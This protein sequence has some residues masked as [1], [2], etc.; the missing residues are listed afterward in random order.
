MRF[1]AHLGIAALAVVAASVATADTRSFSSAIAQEV[2]TT[3]ASTSGNDQELT[4][5]LGRDVQTR[6]EKDLGRIVD[7]LADSSGKVQAAVVELG[8]FLGIGTR[9]IVVEWS[10][11]TFESKD[12][13]AK[14]VLE[15]DRAQLRA[16]PEY[17][18]TQ[19]VVGRKA[20]D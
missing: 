2:G 1:P 6:A 15:M 17:K 13:S 9:K 5:V 19:P 18:P 12:K 10:A 7:V 11:L 8:G 4:S 16:A 3:D 20:A 14:V